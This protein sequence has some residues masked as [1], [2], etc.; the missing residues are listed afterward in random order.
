[1]QPKRGKMMSIWQD[2]TDKSD[3]LKEIR[4]FICVIGFLFSFL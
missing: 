3:F 2:G 1:M 4:G